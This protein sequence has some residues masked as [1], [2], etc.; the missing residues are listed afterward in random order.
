MII[1]GPQCLS[2]VN[3]LSAASHVI[4]LKEG[5][6]QAQGTPAEID[7]HG[8]GLLV[9]KQARRPEEGQI[10]IEPSGEEAAESTWEREEEEEPIAK[11]S[12]GSTPYLFFARMVTW[13]NAAFCVVCHYP[14]L[15]AR[16]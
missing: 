14:S 4:V 1:L 9:E 16:T 6:I 12:L 11:S 8:H 10:E 5:R 15:G 13:K 3:H 7:Q 2:L